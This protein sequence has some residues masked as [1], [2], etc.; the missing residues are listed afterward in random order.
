MRYRELTKKRDTKCIKTINET[1]KMMWIMRTKMMW[2]MR[3][4][5]IKVTDFEHT[6]NT[7]NVLQ[8]FCQKEEKKD[9]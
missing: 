2:I 4:K 8:P 3:T 6:Q 5:I 7:T 1:L 9:A